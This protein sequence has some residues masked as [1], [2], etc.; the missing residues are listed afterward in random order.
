MNF[1]NSFEF[2]MKNAL[3]TKT[4]VVNF[5]ARVSVYSV[6]RNLPEGKLCLVFRGNLFD[7]HHGFFA[8]FAVKHLHGKGNDLREVLR[9]TLVFILVRFQAALNIDKAS[10]FEVFLADLTQA[11]PGFHVDPFGIFLGL[12]FLALPAVADSK[13]EVRHFLAGGRE[14]AFGILTQIADQ[15]DTI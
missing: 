1:K 15:L 6:V 14:L 8:W 7:G 4:R 10:L 12:A 2:V 13:A 11:A 3:S 5:A 9:L